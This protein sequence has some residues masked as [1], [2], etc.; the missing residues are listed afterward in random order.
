MKITPEKMAQNK[1]TRKLYTLKWENDMCEANFKI[2]ILLQKGGEVESTL[3][4]SHQFLHLTTTSTPLTT[5][6]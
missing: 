4:P 2:R 3:A 6:S 1:Q 5:S